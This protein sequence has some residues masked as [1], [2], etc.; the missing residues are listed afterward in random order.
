MDFGWTDEQLARRRAAL[1]F[2]R[3]ELA[4]D[5]LAARDRDGRFS[6]ELWA[7]C[8]RFGLLRLSV[9]AAQGGEELDLPTAM[10]VMEA[11][12]E[13]YTYADVRFVRA[14]LSWEAETDGDE[15]E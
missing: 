2:A 10:L 13:G 14:A 6:P 8:A 15:G 4:D 3:A 5:E 1:D 9:P 7:R 12:G 11:L